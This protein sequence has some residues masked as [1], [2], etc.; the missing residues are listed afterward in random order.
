MKRTIT[1][2]LSVMLSLNILFS[3]CACSNTNES[4]TSENN[5]YSD[6][7]YS[8]YH[9]FKQDIKDILGKM[10]LENPISQKQQLEEKTNEVNWIVSALLASLDNLPNDSTITSSDKKEIEENIGE[11]TIE[12]GESL[13]DLYK[14]DYD[15][16]SALVSQYNQS[17]MANLKYLTDLRFQLLDNILLNNMP[18]K[19]I[20]GMEDLKTKCVYER[21][22][23]ITINECETTSEKRLSD[24][25]DKV[26][27]DGE[28][29][30]GNYYELVANETEDYSGVI[31]KIGVIKNNDWS[32]QMTEKSPFIGESGLLSKYTGDSNVTGSIYDEKFAKFYYIGNGCFYYNNTIVNGNNGKSYNGYEH[33]YYMPVVQCDRENGEDIMICNDDGKYILSNYG[34]KFKVLDAETMKTETIDVI[35]DFGIDYAFPYAEGLFACMNHYSDNESNGFYNLKGEKVID[36]S[37]YKL[38]RNTY[39]SSASYGISQ[40]L[41]FENGECTFKITNELGTDYMITINKKGDVVNSEEVD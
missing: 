14:H 7:I 34:E 30:N 32:I 33:E 21:K 18:S 10:S 41:V 3:L 23:Y 12:I 26:L 9:Y 28:D 22:E 15:N 16:S 29:E 39:D 19:N 6:I 31:I 25:C 20:I 4:K 13:S 36:L 11:L 1:I 24:D 2:M 38:A 40:S 8:L 37:K 35:Q 5:E 27:A 17:L